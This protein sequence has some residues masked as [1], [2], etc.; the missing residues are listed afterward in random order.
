MSIFP[1]QQFETD[2][3]ELEADRKAYEKLSAPTSIVVRFGTMRMVGEFPYSGDSKPG[4]G[5]KLVCR[6]PRGTEVGEML[7][8]TCPNAGCS[9]SVTRKEMLEYI[10]NSG[11]KDYPFYNKG[12]VLR[13]A[14]IE[15]MNQQSHIEGKAHSMRQFAQKRADELK[16]DMKIVQAEPILEIGRASCRERV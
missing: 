13:I 11:G 3:K 1:L 7:T 9:K 2:L 12:R 4:C 15:D 10:G 16:L 8:S 14:A 6:T 5:S